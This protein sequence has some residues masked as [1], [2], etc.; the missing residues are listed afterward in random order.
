MLPRYWNIFMFLLLM[1]L[2]VLY[3]LRSEPGPWKGPLDSIPSWGGS[4]RGHPFFVRCVFR[5]R[6][7]IGDSRHI[8]KKKGDKQKATR[9]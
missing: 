5:A 7:M 4:K 6:N 8:G 3:V 2:V 9:T 1:T